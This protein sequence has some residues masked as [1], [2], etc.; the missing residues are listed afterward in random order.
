MAPA[1]DKASA[2]PESGS[3]LP[4]LKRVLARLWPV[5]VALAILVYLFAGIPREAMWVAFK[6]GPWLLLAGYTVLQVFLALLADVYA[7]RVALGIMGLKLRFFQIFLVR[8][9]TYLLG[10]LNY[11]LGQGALGFYLQRSGLTAAR[12]TGIILFLL[13]VNFGVLLGMSGLGLWAGGLPGAGFLSPS[14][15]ALYLAGG[16]I[17]YLTI[18]ALRPRFLQDWRLTAPLLEAGF[19]GHLRAATGRVPHVLVLILTYWGALRLWGIP[20]PLL[21]GLVLIPVVLFIGAL[22]ITPAGLGTT[23]AAMVILFSPYVP[24]AN[25][26]ARAAA[27]LAFSL[28][29]Y[30]WGITIQ[31]S[32]GLWCC[33]KIQGREALH[34]CASP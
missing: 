21:E 4:G 7:I 32:L 16:M 33:R 24:L 9:A 23:Q 1:E 34:S 30:F 17:A 19:S 13:V 31:A 22:P 14:A 8:G 18:V 6:T 12:A 11:A 20:V 3:S 15:L 29:A 25:P 26:E 10:L 5:L 27:V 28:V 2:S